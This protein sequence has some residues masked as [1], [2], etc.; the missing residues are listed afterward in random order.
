MTTNNH[1]L[2]SIA[3]LV[4]CLLNSVLAISQNRDILFENISSQDG[5]SSNTVFTAIQDSAGYMWFGTQDGLNRYDGYA[6]AV[7]RPSE[8]E[9]KSNSPASVHIRSLHIDS[10]A[11]LW[12][13]GDEGVTRY[14][15]KHNTFENFQLITDGA[16]QYVSAISETKDGQIWACLLNGKCFV[17][18]QQLNSFKEVHIEAGITN[19]GTLYAIEDGF[20]VGSDFGLYHLN[21]SSLKMSEIKLLN[22]SFAVN[23]VTRSHDGTFW[24]ASSGEGILHIDNKFKLIKQYKHEVFNSNSLC[25]NNVRSLCFD[26]NGKLWIGTFVGLSIFDLATNHFENHFEEFSRP[27]ALTQNSV[28]TIIKDRD[29]G[30]WL[31]TFFGGVDYYHP[32]NIKFDLLNQNGGNLSLSDNVVSA[33]KEAPNGNIWILT[34]DK[35]LN[36]W[37]RKNNKIQFIT[38]DEKDPSSIS[39]N[40]LKSVIYTNA[41]NLLIGTHDLGLNYYN[42]RTKKNIVFKNK[43]AKGDI[44]NNNVYALLKDSHSN[45][46]VGTWKGLCKFNERTL[47]FAQ[48]NTDSKGNAL[49]SELISYLYED[50]RG[51]IWIGTFNGLNIFYPEKNLFETFKIDSSANLNLLNDDIT[52][53]YEDTK[54]R[55]WIGTRK[56]LHLFDELERNFKNITTKDG[57]ASNI[58]YGVLEDDNNNLWI[59]SN[60]GLSCYNTKTKRI[61][62]Y[63]IKDGIQASQ[64]NN[65]SFC[66]TSDGLLL[67]GGINGLTIFDPN[68]VE[69]TPFNSN[70]IFTYFKLFN[71]VIQPGDSS[72]ILEQGISHTKKIT[73]KHNQNVFSIGFAAINYIGSNNIVYKYKLEGYDQEWREA[74]SGRNAYYSNLQPGNYTFKVIAEDID[75]NSDIN[76]TSLTIEILTSWWQST[77]AYILY[78]ALFILL[79]MVSYKLIRERIRTQN[80]LRLEILEKHQI[81]EVN[82]MKLQFFTNISH[83]FRTPLTL[84]ISPLQKIIERKGADEWLNRQH[85]TIY[86]NARRLI[87]LIDQLMDFRK[88]ELGQLRLNTAPGDIVSYINE[89]YLSFALA[90]SQNNIVYTFDSEEPKIDC[91]FDRSYIEKIAFNLLSN[92]FKFT[93]DGGTVGIKLYIEDEWLVFEVKDTGK[94]IPP[95]KI[96]LIFERFYRIDE[97]SS[98]TGSGIGLALTK[99]LVELHHGSIAVVGEIN[100]GSTFTVRLPLNSE[101]YESN[102]VN[103]EQSTVQ[104]HIE[105]PITDVAISKSKLEDEQNI[106]EKELILLVDDNTDISSYIKESLSYEYKIKLVSN[107][108]EALEFLMNEEPSLIISDIMMPVMDGLSLCKTLKQSVKT[109]HIPIILL[110]AK[111]SVDDQIE[112][113]H[114]GADDYMAKPF[115]MNLLEAKVHNLIKT[116]KR[117]K[118]LFSQ[119]HDIKPEAIAFN[120]LDKEFLEKAMLVVEEHLIDPKFSVDLF[121]QEMN[122]SRSNLHLKMKAITGASA[123]DFIKKIRFSE[124]IKLLEENRYSMAEISF[125]TGFNSPSYFSTSFKKHFG[126]L[127]TEHIQKIK[128]RIN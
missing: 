67:F 66:K 124:A 88:S 106:D 71:N 87:N 72:G 20:L 77:I 13:G 97:A 110:T 118:E 121:A 120:R 81:T 74:E 21:T 9:E 92:A 3:L 45:I 49:S 4:L 28:R 47:S 64:F 112:G 48:H 101:V 116:R 94:G 123:T 113:L 93:P 6:F 44:P 127:P 99:R 29:N 24:I 22:S 12:I 73:L 11:I 96:S 34:N 10:K 91:L 115:E 2:R 108:K 90:A 125:K 30:M 37:D 62:N 98:K 122:M 109:C 83:E 25:N 69:E 95:E 59:S 33:I 52:C 14:E 26:N 53:V 54:G 50:S 85:E 107:G 100:K 46:W 79:I 65:Y 57:L 5:L 31:G 55:I 86:K 27:Y 35:G 76:E 114:L 7:Y 128:N 39:S 111:T 51:R 104:E 60:N 80:Q 89:I 70:V 105:L 18:N 8:S 75:D 43:G 1:C 41:Q 19:I 38:H 126:Y 58:I 17:Y 84:I 119:T 82:K 117:L 78:L 42:P 63:G 23:Q 61:R 102:E 36:Y 40:N 16:R 103:Y 32:A 15:E 56:G 68:K